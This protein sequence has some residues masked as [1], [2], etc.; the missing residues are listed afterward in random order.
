MK[1]II[2]ILLT[3]AAFGQ[4][5]YVGLGATNAGALYA[6]GYENKVRI[7]L[8]HKVPFTR[9]DV[10]TITALTAGYR[11][12]FITPSIGL[13]NTKVIGHSVEGKGMERRAVKMIY[14]V[15]FDYLCFFA[16]ANYCYGAYYGAGL[17]VYFS[18]L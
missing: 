13:A 8:S 18:K 7:E 3:S 12:N 14:S 4:G 6:V 16:N 17:R 10:K 15:S 5:V 2:L 1:T 9:T 11:L